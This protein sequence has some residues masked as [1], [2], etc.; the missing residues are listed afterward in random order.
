MRW[1]F[2]DDTYTGLC[3]SLN[4]YDIVN[5]VEGPIT[6]DE[7]I[8]RMV[9]VLLHSDGRED[10][11]YRETMS[12]FFEE[13]GVLPDYSPD[14]IVELLMKVETDELCRDVRRVLSQVKSEDI[15]DIEVTLQPTGY[16]IELELQ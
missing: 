16:Q 15:A 8:T 4:E 12:E 13:S 7:V 6:N 2:S 10:E 14:D 11:F 1:I 9:N 5:L 3:D